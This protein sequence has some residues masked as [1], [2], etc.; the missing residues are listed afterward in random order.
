MDIGSIVGAVLGWLLVFVAIA[1][2]G[3]RGFLN[4]PSILIT[5]GGAIAATL[6]HYPLPQVTAVMRVARKALFMKELDYMKVYEE[7]TD[8][9]VRARRDGLLALEGDI[10]KIEDP[11]MKKGLQMAV[12]GN[13]M[14]VLRSV[15]EDEMAAMQERHIIGQGIFKALGNYAPAFGMIGTL[16][17]LVAMLQNM[18][19][20]ASLGSGM[21]VALLTTMYGAMVANLVALPTAGKLEQR[22]QE[23]VAL[24]TMVLEGIVAILEGHSP[25]IVEEKLRAF[26]PPSVRNKTVK[27]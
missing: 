14:E 3:G 18:S 20:P 10:E 4:I 25:R 23:E 15:L 5:V 1:M 11:F 16:V 24:K 27:E 6:I 2:G 8:Y 22:S 12:D 19:D 7:L 13:S 9:A 26:M 21:A 17:G